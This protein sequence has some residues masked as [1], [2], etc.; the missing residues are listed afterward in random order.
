MKING[1]QYSLWRAADQYGEVV[2]VHLQ[3]NR[4]DAAAKSFFKRLLRNHGR[5]PGKIAPDKLRSYPVSHRELIPE[6]IHVADR[7]TNNRAEQSHEAARVREQG[8]PKVK[9]V[10]QAQRFLTGDAALSY[11]T[12]AGIWSG[13]NNIGISG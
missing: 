2:D 10:S 6:V 5:E 3:E 11:S 12:L 4:E 1:K 7:H 9:S 13:R 8:I